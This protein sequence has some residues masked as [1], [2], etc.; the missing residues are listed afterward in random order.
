[1]K[2]VKAQANEQAAERA[3]TAA[4]YLML[5]FDNMDNMQDFLSR[6]NLPEQTQIVK[7]EELL[8]MMESI[9]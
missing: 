3:E 9:E 8:A 5:S 6:F 1:M 7:G 2:D 4:A